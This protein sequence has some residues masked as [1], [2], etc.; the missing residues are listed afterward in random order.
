MPIYVNGNSIHFHATPQVPSS[1][2]F[3]TTAN[4]ALD[5]G[6]TNQPSSLD[7]I[8]QTITPQNAAAV[9]E[10]SIHGSPDGFHIAGGYL[11]AFNHLNG[12]GSFPYEQ[13][14][15]ALYNSGG[16]TNPPQYGLS[17]I[18]KQPVT[19]IISSSGATAE[20]LG[21]FRLTNGQAL[22]KGSANDSVNA[23]QGADPTTTFYPNYNPSIPV[24]NSTKFPVAAS[25]TGPISVALTTDL[26]GNQMPGQYSPIA[27]APD[28][29]NSG[30]YSLSPG[31]RA[32]P[33]SAPQISP[34]LTAADKNFYMPWASETKTNFGP[35]LTPLLPQMI[36]ADSPL[37]QGFGGGARWVPNGHIH[38]WGSAGGTPSSSQGNRF[39]VNYPT[40]SYVTITTSVTFT[41]NPLI[42]SV[43]GRNIALSPPGAGI[44][45]NMM[46]VGGGV[47]PVVSTPQR[48]GITRYPTASATSI[49]N[50][51]PLSL[52]NFAP[53]PQTPRHPD[54]MVAESGADYLFTYGGF[55][56]S[57]AY[58]RYTYRLPYAS[59][60][61]A[62]ITFVPTMWADPTASPGPALGFGKLQGFS[63]K[64]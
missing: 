51:S 55:S 62:S 52:S 29:A 50:P 25:G 37:R 7:T 5:I 60:N 3:A 13:A 24:T 14:D 49:G 53:V 32:S 48:G 10:L 41:A 30:L 43:G 58:Q 64:V 42:L 45:S 31:P 26:S 46:I 23:Y 22:Y 39:G 33:R 59:F 57:A 47:N 20:M 35:Q 54:G 17:R 16:L 44:P 61:T 19:A 6:P 4:S 15:I 63:N 34:Y 8:K 38:Y 12:I 9:K 40:S 36:T 21:A 11:H 27:S 2:P 18:T 56:N 1:S 28:R